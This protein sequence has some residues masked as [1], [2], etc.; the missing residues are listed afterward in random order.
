MPKSA[1]HRWEAVFLFE[2]WK[3]KAHEFCV[4][5]AMGM[6]MGM[7]GDGL[8]LLFPNSGREW[9]K[10]ERLKIRSIAIQRAKLEHKQSLYV[11]L[12]RHQLGYPG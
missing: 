5:C 1:P 7:G 2:G 12:Q 10:K 6:G 3:P 11:G 9:E 4:L 8:K